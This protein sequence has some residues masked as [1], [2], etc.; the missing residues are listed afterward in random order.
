M[1]PGGPSEV[2]AV[3]SGGGFGVDAG[4]GVVGVDG[5]GEGDVGVGFEGELLGC[6]HLLSEGSGGGG[7]GGEESEGCGEVCFGFV[8]RQ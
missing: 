4:D 6:G 7:E 3:V 8:H 5:A 2:E 1:L